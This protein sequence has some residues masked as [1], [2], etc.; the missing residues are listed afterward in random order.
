MDHQLTLDG[1]LEQT[2]RMAPQYKNFEVIQAF[3]K[4]FLSELFN[5]SKVLNDLESKRGLTSAEGSQIDRNGKTLGIKRPEGTNDSIYRVFTQ[6]QAGVNSSQADYQ[7]IKDSLTLLFTT[8]T[9]KEPS[10]EIYSLK[11]AISCEFNSDTPE[12]LYPVILSRLLKLVRACVHIASLVKVS[13]ESFRFSSL[14]KSY[15]P[16]FNLGHFSEEITK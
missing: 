9:T 10:V 3:R 7:S 15:S 5:I 16:G 12:N 8:D 2:N 6:A 14:D 13:N 11:N 1:Y 4:A